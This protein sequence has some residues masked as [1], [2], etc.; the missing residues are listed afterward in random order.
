MEEILKNLTSLN[1]QD[2]Q[3]PEDEKFLKLFQQFQKQECNENYFVQ[4]CNST[5]YFQ[6]FE[7]KENIDFDQGN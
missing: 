1:Q 3:F 2:F 6:K 7:K 5:E 4:L